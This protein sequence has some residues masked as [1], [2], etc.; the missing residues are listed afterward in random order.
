MVKIFSFVWR[1]SLYTHFIHQKRSDFT[2]YYTVENRG[3]MFPSPLTLLIVMNEESNVNAPHRTSSSVKRYTVEKLLLFEA[4]S[5]FMTSA[6]ITFAST[7]RDNKSLQFPTL[8]YPTLWGHF[9]RGQQIHLHR[10]EK[11]F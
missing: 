11:R 10:R 9:G 8:L 2:T 3:E 5:G 4:A 1:S 6:I 7:C